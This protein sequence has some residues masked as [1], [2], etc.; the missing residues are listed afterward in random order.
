M[1]LSNSYFKLILFFNIFIMYFNMLI[2]LNIYFIFNNNNFN[3]IKYV[4]YFLS[5]FKP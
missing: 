4:F 2:I 3:K 1:I 5:N